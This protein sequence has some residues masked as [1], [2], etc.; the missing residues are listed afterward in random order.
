M[1][2]AMIRALLFILLIAVGPAFAQLPDPTVPPAVLKEMERNPKDNESDQPELAPAQRLQSVLI[3]PK[4]RVAVIDGKT[5]REGALHQGAI[6]ASIRAT[7]VVLTKNG[8]KETLRLY[9]A[10]APKASADKQR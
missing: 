10:P 1:D 6:V 5:V 3:S 7:Y 2:E 4:R 9:P 8:A